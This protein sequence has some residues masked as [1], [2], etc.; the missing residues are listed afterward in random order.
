MELRVGLPGEADATV[1]LDVFLGGE[2]VGLRGR[3]ARS[4]G[5]QRQIGAAVGEHHRA[6]VGVG[7]RQLELHV[8]VGE[9]VLDR[10]VRADGAAERITLQGIVARH[11]HG[12][13]R[14]AHLREGKVDRGAIV[15]PLQ[16]APAFALGAQ[17]FGRRVGE[18]E[19]AVL[20]CG[21]D[22]LDVLFGD[23]LLT[24]VDQRQRVLGQH[25]GERRRPAVGHRHL[26]SVQPPAAEQRAH[27][28]GPRRLRTF[29]GRQGPDRLAGG[30]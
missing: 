23:A 10:L 11:V 30:Q 20:A 25:D 7:A 18:G 24:K 28:A 16:Q 22:R 12:R 15:E 26:L 4:G 6:V 3:D 13:F 27:V 29:R 14:A 19:F 5:G 8:A 17:Q 1:R 21:I 2:V 9:L